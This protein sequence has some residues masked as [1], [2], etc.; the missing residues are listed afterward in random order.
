VDSNPP[1]G[2]MT[3]P[4]DASG[5]RW[6][7]GEQWTDYRTRASGTPK[8]SRGWR[9]TPTLVAVA[10]V[11]L[12]VA[13]GVAV[14]G[15]FGGFL[16]T[17]GLAALVVAIVGLVR[18]GVAAF[19]LKG[20]ATAGVLLAGS[21]GVLVLGGGVN[22]AT[23]PPVADIRPLVS[24]SAGPETE[25]RHI[26]APVVRTTVVTE[27]EPIPFGEETVEDPGVASG[28]SFVST[29]G[30]SG[31]LTV[32]YSVTTQDGVEIAREKV[33]ERVTTAPIDQVT[34]VGTKVEQRAPATGNG[35]DP[36]YSGCVP[37]AS[38]VDCAGGSGNGPAYATGPVT[39]IGRDIYDL[40]RDGDGVACD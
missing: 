2:W 10:A 23:R 31:V 5:L 37:I 7:N 13:M 20:K 29:V 36:N 40:D 26:V 15:G 4:D 30:V 1:A 16:S 17:L 3:D 14:S 27:Q 28:E 24:S 33:D 6:W 11:A 8:R 39:V 22:A 34:T 38:D 12:I 35:C 9:P 21:I 18:G 32:T 19:G 25:S